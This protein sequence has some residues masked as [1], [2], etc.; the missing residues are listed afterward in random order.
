MKKYV[1]TNCNYSFLAKK[2]VECNFCG[3]KNIEEVKSADELL[4]EIDKLF[5][6]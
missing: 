3:N 2:A 4:D 6:N 5:N 1:C